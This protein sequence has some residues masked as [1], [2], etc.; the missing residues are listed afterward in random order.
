MPDAD[1]GM[2]SICSITSRNRPG[3]LV[4]WDI[5]QRDGKR[6]IR[7]GD[8][9]GQLGNQTIHTWGI[10]ASAGAYPNRHKQSLTDF[11]AGS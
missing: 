9:K 10:G 2:A 6:Y 1:Y 7:Y 3:G 11:F 8:E 5:G 4:H